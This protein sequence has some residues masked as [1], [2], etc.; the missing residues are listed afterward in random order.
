M[1]HLRLLIGG[2][3]LVASFSASAA[4]VEEIFDM[5][6][7]LKSHYGVEVKQ[8]MK[9]TIFHDDEATSPQPFVVIDHGRGANN[10]NMGRSRFLNQSKYYVS[11]GFVAV[12]PT[13][14]GYGETGGPDLDTAE[15]CN[16]PRYESAF[17]I[18]ATE[19]AQVVEFAK[20]KPY[21]D[22]TKGIVSGLSYGGTSAIA[23]AALNIPG[24]VG[25]INFAGG[26]GGNPAK[27]PKNPCRSDLIE[28]EFARLGKTAKVPTLWLY[29]ENDLYFG[30]EKSKEW[31]DAFVKA[32]GTAEFVKLPA[33]GWDGH[34]IFLK[35]QSAWQ[36]AVE[37][38]IKT[39]GL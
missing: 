27:S 15:S 2:T 37:R 35:D 22:P 14:V 34:T 1:P 21:V 30:T 17:R 3:L 11:K 19:V 25:A 9:V 29:S 7:A 33:F 39:V 4:M 16:N 12:V 6:V 38:F 18:L 8:T 32:G 23:A 13:R 24:V 31:M 28:Y 10:L 5:P 20:T 36:P 26:A